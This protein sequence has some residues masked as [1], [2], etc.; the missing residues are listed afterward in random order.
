MLKEKPRSVTVWEAKHFIAIGTFW[1]LKVACKKMEIDVHGYLSVTFHSSAK[2][3]LREWWLKMDTIT[4]LTRV[5]SRLFSGCFKPL[6]LDR[7]VKADSS[8][9]WHRVTRIVSCF[10][11]VWRGWICMCEWRPMLFHKGINCSNFRNTY[12]NVIYISL[13]KTFTFECDAYYSK[14]SKAKNV[15]HLIKL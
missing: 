7:H 2:Y 13:L 9:V 15:L 1:F 6:H 11:Q 4:L 5:C 10:A 8:A 12:L 14:T 3:I